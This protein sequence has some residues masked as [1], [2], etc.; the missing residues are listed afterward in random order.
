[1]EN[2]LFKNPEVRM[3]A[4]AIFEM[5]YSQPHMRMK[6]KIMPLMKNSYIKM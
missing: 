4:N 6:K 2:I 1:M 5:S 3:L